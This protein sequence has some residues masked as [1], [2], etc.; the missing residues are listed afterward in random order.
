MARLIVSAVSN[1]SHSVDVVGRL[2]VF[3][4]VSRASDGQ[5]VT[6]LG[7]DNFRIASSLGSV[8]DPRLALVSEV[9][10]EPASQEPSGCYRLSIERGRLAAGESELSGAWLKGESYAFGI[11]VRVFETHLIDGQ[12]VEVPVDW[13]QVVLRVSSLGT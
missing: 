11:Q 10:W 1:E 6:G 3:V 13:G 9:E 7:L 8:L 4:S 12:S 5:P 2:L